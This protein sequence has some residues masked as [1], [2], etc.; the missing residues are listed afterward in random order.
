MIQ[1]KPLV[2]FMV[3]S[4]LFK[5]LGLKQDKIE[6]LERMIAMKIRDHMQRSIAENSDSG[7]Q[8]GEDSH[9]VKKIQEIG[10]ETSQVRDESQS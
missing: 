8:S 9:K 7:I 4:D 10:K 1:L 5:R 6:V 2:K 3:T